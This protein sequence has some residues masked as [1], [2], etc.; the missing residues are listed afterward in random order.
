M[1]SNLSPPPDEG[2][3][4]GSDSELPVAES[5]RM[6]EGEREEDENNSGAGGGT[7]G[8]I[9]D[10]QK[11]KKPKRGGRPKAD[12]WELYTTYGERNERT[13]RFLVTCN[14]CGAIID[15]RVE[16]MER[17]IGYDCQRI[18]EPEKLKWQE[19]VVE[20]VKLIKEEALNYAT[21]TAAAGVGAGAIVL[22]G[23]S[24]KRPKK[25]KRGEG[26]CSLGRHTICILFGFVL[27]FCR[28]SS[29]LICSQCL[30]KSRVLP[31]GCWV[32][33]RAPGFRQRREP[34]FTL[35]LRCS[36]VESVRLLSSVF[37]RQC[38]ILT[39]WT[40]MIMGFRLH[41]D[42]C[43]HIHCNLPF[44][45]CSPGASACSDHDGDGHGVSWCCWMVS[46]SEKT[47]VQH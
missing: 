20:K 11:K 39:P 34:R 31:S 29:L 36:T 7:P 43:W 27:H 9:E 1:D 38:A 37:L 10:K 15:G 17:H 35:T 23:S 16:G 5:G 22:K 44:P 21:A 41:L 13:R 26:G 25:I 33:P 46:R 30:W 12:V 40:L 18:P 47:L 28:S 32:S 19:R 8:T 4:G 45:S 2:N 3:H 42:P 6:V 14:A 24:V